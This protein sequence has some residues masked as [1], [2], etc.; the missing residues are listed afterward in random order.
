M[1]HYSDREIK[2]LAATASLVICK[3]ND[4]IEIEYGAYVI[5]G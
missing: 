5:M 3:N 1:V 2:K 4:K